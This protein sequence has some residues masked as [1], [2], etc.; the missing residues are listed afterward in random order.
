MANEERRLKA[1]AHGRRD[2]IVGALREQ[3]THEQVA[4]R[5]SVYER[6]GLNKP[7]FWADWQDRTKNPY[8]EQPELDYN[9]LASKQYEPKDYFKSNEF[10]YGK[11]PGSGSG[12]VKTPNLG[13][14]TGSPPQVSGPSK[15]QIAKLNEQV[16]KQQIQLIANMGSRVIARSALLSTSSL[17]VLDANTIKMSTGLSK[18]YME[19]PVGVQ[20]STVATKYFVD[21]ANASAMIRHDQSFS[22]NA[23]SNFI[24]V[25]DSLKTAKPKQTLKGN[26]K[27][28]VK[29]PIV[30]KQVLKS[31]MTAQKQATKPNINVSQNSYSSSYATPR[32]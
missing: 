18:A 15:Q 23:S 11:Q 26:T 12:S 14:Y 13:N 30:Q 20:V 4:T 24:Q 9:D 8:G 7:G 10:D 5:I 21:Q 28:I 19:A 31:G 32:W 16:K 1:G 6:L 17:D 27:G 2:P 3:S 22:S 29:A 25:Q